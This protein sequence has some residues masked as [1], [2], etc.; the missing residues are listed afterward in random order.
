MKKLLL[1]LVATLG[2]SLAAM[3]QDVIVKKNAEEVQAKVKSI[4]LNEIMYLRWDNLDGPTY[5]IPKS[6]VFFI[7]YANGQKETFTDYVQTPAVSTPVKREA[8]KESF[9]KAK[10]QGYT[11]LGADFA[12]GLGGPSL[13]FSFGVRTSKCFYI[14]AGIG[15]H[16]VIGKVELGGYSDYYHDDYYDDDYYGDYSSEYYNSRATVWVPYL[17]FTS[18]IKAYI[19]TQNS[20]FFPRFDLSF[21]GTVDAIDALA[22]FY[23][24]F[25]A[26]FDYR[27]FSFGIGYQMPVYANVILPLGY[28]RLGVRFGKR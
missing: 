20:D 8:V 21:G 23:M 25:G 3:A 1:F 10:F 19:P 22:G 2:V 12:G 18:D 14:G 4:G 13:D 15:W 9:S 6:E 27:R 16:N 7:K 17:T 28:I 24:S 5:Y 11:Y 26:A